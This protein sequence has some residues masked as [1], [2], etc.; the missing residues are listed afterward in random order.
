MRYLVTGGAGFIGSHLTQRLLHDGHKV[1]ILDTFT[2]GRHENLADLSHSNLRIFDGSILDRPLLK[3]L[4]I[5][6][7]FI[8]HLAAAVGVF[9]I[10]REPLSSLQTNIQGTESVLE[11]A[12]ELGLPLLVTSSSE[13]YGKNTSEKLNEEDD[14]VL[15]P[16]SIARWSYSEAKAIDE[17]LAISFHKE[18]SLPTRIVRLFNTVG[19]RQVGNYGMVIPRFVCSALKNENIEIYGTGEQTRCFTHV[20]DVIDALLLIAN[21]DNTIGEV[22]NIGNNSEITISNLAK[23]IISM[24]DSKSEIVY[25]KYEEV[26]EK[27][28][29]DMQ[30]RVPDISKIKRLTGWAPTRD[31]DSI[32]LDV[33]A[34]EKNG[35]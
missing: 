1:T 16:T 35:H 34:Y 13:V 33:I 23:K 15:G 18:F 30:R 3:K 29:E 32:L 27:D 19:P 5:D 20:L 8:F 17:F 22:I 2:T 26:Y 31:L 9:N 11:I 14:R 24:T 4:A 10:V 25:K 12:K 21:S 7:D 28:F 6:V